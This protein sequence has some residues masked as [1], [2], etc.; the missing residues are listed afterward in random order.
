[1]TS[2]HIKV[3]AHV[4]KIPKITLLDAFDFLWT[5]QCKQARIFYRVFYP[6]KT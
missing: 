3:Y 6:K 2:N 4:L 1:M 5:K